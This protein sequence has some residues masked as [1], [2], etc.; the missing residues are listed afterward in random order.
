MPDT[1]AHAAVE[2]ED[3]PR[4]RQLLD[5]GADIQD[6]TGD[7]WTLLH[8]AIDIE[9]DGS[10]QTGAPLRVSTTAF[11]LARGADPNAADAKGQSP[12]DLARY[13]RHWLAVELIEA[14]LNRGRLS[15]DVP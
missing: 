14:W 15:I 4:L 8:H 5:D 9:I 10:D 11:L 12:L 1:P 6:P 3:L 13:R 2:L 7:G